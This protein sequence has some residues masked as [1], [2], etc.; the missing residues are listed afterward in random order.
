MNNI[1]LMEILYAG[2]YLVEQLASLGLF[3][4][5]ISYDIVKELST[6]GILHDQVQLFWRFYNLVKLDDVWVP[7][8]FED[9]DLTSH[10]L[11][12]MDVLNFVLL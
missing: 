1:Q 9:M 2:N 10:S 3:D 4:S 8:H 7:D 6:L 5:L 12:V 11:N